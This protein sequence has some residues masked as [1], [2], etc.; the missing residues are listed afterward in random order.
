[1]AKLLRAL[2]HHF[3]ELESLEIFPTYEHGRELVLPATFLSGSTPSLRQLTLRE[4]LSSCLSPLLSSATGLVELAL[5]LRIPRN[6]LPETSFIANLQRMS[7]LRRLELELKFLPR[8]T[9]NDESPPAASTG[10]IVTL[11]KL[12][13]LVFT[14]QRYYLEA[15]VAVLAAPSLQHLDAGLRGATCVFPIPHLCRFICDTDNQ[16]I[17]VRLNISRYNLEFSAG[18]GSQSVYDQPFLIGIHQ[19][20]SLEKMGQE[21]SGP[22]STV[23]EL[24]IA[25]GVELWDSE[26]RDHLR[27]FCYYVPQVKIV[28]V[29]A[30]VAL[31]VAHS[32]QQD[33]R[34]P[35]LDLLPAL[36]R[37]E[38]RSVVG[39]D[40]LYVSICDAFEPLIAARQRAGRPIR[41]SWTFWRNRVTQKWLAR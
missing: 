9:I 31:N 41:L 22:L 40:D 12:M 6:A 37:V 36:E 28:Q 1:M 25:W 24:I 3:P 27:G 23:E 8:T 10:D 15:L 39:E 38:V 30:E 7:R 29:P 32:F 13:Q 17:T 19:P 35:I 2:S 11:P 18:T 4:V 16:F 21:L 33:G 20:V 26:S 14:G 5:T 34:E